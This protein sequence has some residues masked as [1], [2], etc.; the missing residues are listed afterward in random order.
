MSTLTPCSGGKTGSSDLMLDLLAA[1]PYNGEDLRHWYFTKATQDPLI[2]NIKPLLT[3]SI[4]VMGGCGQ[5]GSHLITKLYEFGFPVEQLYINDNLSLGQRQNLPEPLQEK[6][7][8]RSHLQYAQN[9]RCKP[10]IVIFVGGRSSAPHFQSLADVTD[11]VETW[12]AVL[13]WCVRANVRLIFAS[14]SSLCKTR[15]SVETQPVWPGSLYEL[16]K[17]L[18]ENMAIQQ[19]LCNDLTVQICRFF[20]VYGVTEKH[21]G[22]VGNLYT[23]LVW[24]A[25]EQQT[26]DVWGQDGNFEPGTQTRDA[27]F[28]SEVC[29]AILHL[30][31]LPKPKPT[32]DDISD[33]IYNIGQGQPTSVAKMVEQVSSLL[34]PTLQ[35]IIQESQVPETLKNYVVHTWGDPQKLLRTGFKPI[36]DVNEDNLKFIIYALLS[37]MDW[38]W[39]GVEK[40]RTHN[41][42]SKY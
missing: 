11:E 14:T 42:R 26:F 4:C 35:P 20:S 38:Y 41:L 16:A 28:A 9:P 10:D 27:I 17:L 32:L 23:Q 18:M 22:Q 21:K 25:I 31:T 29:R 40:I 39:S 2:G 34:P 3:Q 5:V 33:L 13:E 1:L 37:Q 15:P 6:V 19:A 8:V 7:D 30:L 12:K 36:F 24:H